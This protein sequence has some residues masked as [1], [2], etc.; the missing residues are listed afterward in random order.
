VTNG[1][2]T[3]GLGD[4]TLPNMTA[5]SAS[6]FS[7]PNLQ[8]QIW[9][10]D[11]TKGFAALS[12]L[13]N[14]TTVPYAAFADSASNVVG[15]VPASLITGMVAS[16]S[17]P[18][19]AVFTGPVIATSFSGN[20][21]NLTS[22]NASNLVS[23]TVPL[24]CLSGITSNQLA[25]TTWQLATNLNGG[26]AALADA[27][28]AGIAIT[29]ATIISSSFAGNAGG[30]TNLPASQL[31]S[32]GNTNGPAAGNFFVGVAGNST[33]A[34]YNNTGIGIHALGAN[35][36]G[37]NNTAA[38]LNSLLANIGGNDN[39]AI[40]A[41]TLQADLNGGYNTAVGFNA[42]YSNTNG[43]N[44]GIGTYALYTVTNG[45]DNTGIGTY[46]LQNSGSGFGNTAIG[47]NALNA[48]TTGSNNIAL[49]YQA[50][51]TILAGSSN[52]DIGN[53]GFASDA[54]V[55]RIGSG[56][57]A[58]YLVGTVYANNVAISSDRHVK[59]NFTPINPQQVLD[60]VLALPVTEWQYRTDANGIRHIGPMAQDFHAAFG[61]N[62]GD[63]KHI[64][65]VDEGGV[66]LAAIQGLNEELH[67]RDAQIQDLE[68]RLEKLE[69]QGETETKQAK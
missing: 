54:N 58:T 50:G 65:T 24:S 59:E 2:F 32:I 37:L 62:G 56:Q 67:E 68:A 63:D 23:G 27:V 7:Q 33:M 55:I 15:S 9:F 42:L 31:V 1:L 17:L 51:Q 21:T 43:Y 16:S 64:A 66:A 40:G 3:V 36:N 19:N 34:G 44:T 45:A 61:L 25:A 13:Q 30:L 28:A 60:K 12:P 49:G 69:R 39:T 20:G 26:T 11:G 29:N 22:L 57:T 52:I 4:V 14:L 46:A 5:I 38:G 53:V 35:T 10:N 8:L 6:L 18:T 41:Y 48:S 47:Y